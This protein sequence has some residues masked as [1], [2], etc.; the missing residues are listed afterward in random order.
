MAVFGYRPKWGQYYHSEIY[1]WWRL[2]PSFFFF[3]HDW[4]ASSFIDWHMRHVRV[5]YFS[6]WSMQKHW[7]VA[8]GKRTM[9]RGTWP[10]FSLPT[11]LKSPWKWLVPGRLGTDFLPST[12]IG[13]WLA[14]AESHRLALKIISLVHHF[15]WRQ[16]VD[17]E[18]LE[19]EGLPRNAHKISSNYCS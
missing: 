13:S 17:M 1:G 6:V 5:T 12:R 7:Q 4:S 8:A 2:S 10:R 9:G 15:V 11:L 18:K 16:L 3:I 19:G 14:V